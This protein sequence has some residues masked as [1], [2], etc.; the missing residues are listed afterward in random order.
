MSKPF[1]PTRCQQKDPLQKPSV[2]FHNFK[3]KKSFHTDT[4]LQK[5]WNP[6]P[7]PPWENHLRPKGP[8]HSHPA[9]QGV[10]QLCWIHGRAVQ[11]RSCEDPGGKNVERDGSGGRMF[12]CCLFW[13]YVYVQR[14]FVVVD[15]CC[16]DG[17][18]GKILK[19]V[20]CFRVIGWGKVKGWLLEFLLCL[21][22]I[23]CCN[24]LL[25]LWVEGLIFLYTTLSSF[26]RLF[27]LHCQTLLSLSHIVLLICRVLSSVSHSLFSVFLDTLFPSLRVAACWE[28]ATALSSVEVSSM[29]KPHYPKNM[30]ICHQLLQ[31]GWFVSLRFHKKQLEL[32]HHICLYIYII[33][34]NPDTLSKL[35]G[36]SRPLRRNLISLKKQDEQIGRIKGSVGLRGCAVHFSPKQSG[37]EGC[38]IVRCSKALIEPVSKILHYDKRGDWPSNRWCPWCLHNLGADAFGKW[39]RAIGCNW[40]Q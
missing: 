21:G 14:M 17:C 4:N 39:K 28:T 20:Q 22:V 27:Y 23:V 18:R 5:V 35:V 33:N 24:V 16:G 38:L 37:F 2:A 26:S 8:F 11:Q 31:G 3:K 15:V 29:A 9:R 36:C 32:F 19:S 40:I 10:S 30:L 25:T 12:V 6:N 13:L 7:H 34:I 1:K